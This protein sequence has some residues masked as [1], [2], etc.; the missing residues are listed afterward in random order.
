MSALAYH[1]LKDHP[2]AVFDR[3]RLLPAVLGLFRLF[4]LSAGGE[5]LSRQAASLQ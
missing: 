1:I 2:I 5:V 4:G 3:F